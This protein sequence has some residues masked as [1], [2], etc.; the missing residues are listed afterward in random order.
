M[1]KIMKVCL[2]TAVV[3]SSFLCFGC[4]FVP[5]RHPIHPMRPVVVHP[6]VV[7]PIPVRPLPPPRVIVVR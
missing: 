1:E 6:V 7:H 3:L 4:V 2:L 5:V